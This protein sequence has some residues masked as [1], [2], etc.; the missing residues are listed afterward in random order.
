M[1]NNNNYYY[2]NY[3]KVNT[4][5]W[6]WYSL[7]FTLCSYVS[8][9]TRDCWLMYCCL[10]FGIMIGFNVCIVCMACVY[11]NNIRYLIRSDQIT[12]GNSNVIIFI[13]INSNN[14]KT[15]INILLYIHIFI[16]IL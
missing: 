8:S 15:L 11:V 12:S 2:Y 13:I 10:M 6:W 5:T 14:F 9:E 1:K 7:H 4:N 3:N 16:N